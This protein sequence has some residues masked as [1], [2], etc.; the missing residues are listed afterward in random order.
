AGRGLRRARRT[1]A[2]GE[3]E[4]LASR[5]LHLDAEAREGAGGAALF[6]PEEAEQEVLRADGVVA[7]PAGL[8]PGELDGPPCPPRHAGAPARRQLAPLEAALDRAAHLLRR[9]AQAGE[10]LRGDAL[11]VAHQAEQEVLRADVGVVEALGLLLGADEGP[12]RLLG[13]PVELV[14]HGRP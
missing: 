14:G 3:A 11:L 12:L 5:P 1:P 8:L 13:E 2:P 9:D 6:L 7:Q 10:D 4:H